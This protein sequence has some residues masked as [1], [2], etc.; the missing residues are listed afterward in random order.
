MKRNYKKIKSPIGDLHL[1]GH[2]NALTDL[3]FDN[4]WSKQ[5]SQFELAGSNNVLE[6][7]ALQ[8]K[9]YFQKKRTQFDL[10]LE[11]N[12]TDFQKKVWNALLKIPYG[13][14]I[15]YSE[16]AQKIKNPKAIRCVGTTNGKNPIAIIAPCHRVIGKNGSLTG[17]GGGLDMK[18]FLLELEGIKVESEKS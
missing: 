15:S 8:L 16:Q 3:I 11:F 13:K 2:D 17:F 14:T 7:A 18:K 4:S 10:P 12:G 5:K 6:E 1:L 9:E